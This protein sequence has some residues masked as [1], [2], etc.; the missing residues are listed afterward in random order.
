MAVLEHA[1]LRFIIHGQGWVSTRD[2]MKESIISLGAVVFRRGKWTTHTLRT[3]T[4]C[5]SVLYYP[6]RLDWG[7]ISCLVILTYALWDCLLYA[8]VY[9]RV[10]RLHFKPNAC[11][12][13]VCCSSG[14]CG[15]F[16]EPV[17]LFSCLLRS[18]DSHLSDIISWTWPHTNRATDWAVA[19]KVLYLSRYSDLNFSF[20]D[21][22]QRTH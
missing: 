21:F 4:H 11:C 9:V 1:Q 10:W 20:G 5:V 3:H 15:K 7:I 2:V 13:A 16:N 22:T 8:R 18:C 17:S 19:W 6:V 12:L 14:M